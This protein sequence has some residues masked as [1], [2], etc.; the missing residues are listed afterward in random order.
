MPTV[1]SKEIE[2]SSAVDF[3]SSASSSFDNNQKAKTV[4]K[5][6]VG[7]QH[8]F[9]QQN[10]SK[11]V[12]SYDP[13]DGFIHTEAYKDLVIGQAVEK[14]SA[15]CSK[16]TR[17]GFGCL[18]SLFRTNKEES[19]YFDSFHEEYLDCSK[20]AIQ[21]VKE[22]RKLGV[23]DNPLISERENRDKF[24]QEVYRECLVDVH[25][26]ANEKSKHVMRYCI[27]AINFKLGSIH[28]H[29]VCL[30]TLLAVYG[31]TEHDWRI[32]SQAIKSN[33]TGRVSS[34]RH[35]A[36][37]DDRLPD[38]SYTGIEQVF[39][40]NLKITNAGIGRVNETIII[41]YYL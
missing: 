31:F 14:L 5:N 19:T 2:P 41:N 13:E 18:L 4:K 40:D 25:E 3:K 33:P 6:S 16:G 34:L 35:K 7:N 1:F 11:R 26:M 29:E 27:P 32:C 15:C 9:P 21:Y 28:K 22:C 38:I 12:K 8:K 36:W 10:H 30:H 23:A 17:H 24:L 39:R 20:K 37:K